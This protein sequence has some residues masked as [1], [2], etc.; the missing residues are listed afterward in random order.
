[1][2]TCLSNASSHVP[3]RDSLLTTLLRDSLDSSASVTYVLACLNPGMEQACGG[4]HAWG[5][6][7]GMCGWDVWVG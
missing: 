6:C 2:L 1:M 7:V 4:M 5:A 3:F